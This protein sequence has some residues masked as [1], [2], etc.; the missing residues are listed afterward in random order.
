MIIALDIETMADPE[1]VALMPDPAPKANLKDP[2]K[3]IAALTRLI[4][5]GDD[6]RFRFRVS[7][8]H[9]RRFGGCLNG[10]V[11]KGRL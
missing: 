1:A 7:D 8:T 11:M 2:A 9:R 3:R 6:T 5:G 10:F 4:N